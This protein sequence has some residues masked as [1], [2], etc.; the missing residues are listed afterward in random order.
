[1]M[2]QAGVTPDEQSFHHIIMRHVHQG[3]IEMCLQVLAYM[4]AS[5]VAPSVLTMHHIIK[6]A[7]SVGMARLALDLAFGF[8]EQ[9]ARRLET[10]TWMHCLVSCADS[11]YVGLQ[12]P[13][14][15]L[16]SIFS[17]LG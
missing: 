5:G 3:Q 17:T 2:S 7:A 10:E 13:A 1:M 8:E 15:I 11:L 4:Q 12:L 6:E 16:V 14:F 9:D